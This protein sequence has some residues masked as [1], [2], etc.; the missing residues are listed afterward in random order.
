[1]I[2]AVLKQLEAGVMPPDKDDDS[3]DVPPLMTR[4]DVVKLTCSRQITVFS[5][6][7]T[8]GGSKRG[9]DGGGS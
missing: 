7:A 6:T 3:N 2:D 1:M 4:T 5:N 8:S 9:G